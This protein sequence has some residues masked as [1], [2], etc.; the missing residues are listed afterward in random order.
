M[1]TNNC[2]AYTVYKRNSTSPLYEPQPADALQWTEPLA[3]L[4]EEPVIETREHS[5]CAHNFFF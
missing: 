2:I 1:N 3:A 5:P 4:V